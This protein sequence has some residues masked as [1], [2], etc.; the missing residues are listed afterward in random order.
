M[1]YTRSV[2]ALL[3][4]EMRDSDGNLTI[5]MRADR[6]VSHQVRIDHAVLNDAFRTSEVDLA[7]LARDNRKALERA[8]AYAWQY[9]REQEIVEV[10][11]PGHLVI[12]DLTLNDFR[13]S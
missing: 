8:V 5:A 1:E 7:R 3:W 13:R 11:G 10:G 12:L 4:N 9:E 6:T 2:P